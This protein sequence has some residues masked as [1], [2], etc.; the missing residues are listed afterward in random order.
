MANHLTSIPPPL[1]PS[2]FLSV[3]FFPSFL[4]SFSS[5][6]HREKLRETCVGSAACIS[7]GVSLEWMSSATACQASVSQISGCPGLECTD[8]YVEHGRCCLFK[9]ESFICLKGHIWTL[10]VGENEMD[11]QFYFNLCS[12]CIARPQQQLLTSIGE[13]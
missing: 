5:L 3:L 12:V 2:F 1:P 4:P 11:F 13:I 6:N 9:R 8:E 10:P 7:Q